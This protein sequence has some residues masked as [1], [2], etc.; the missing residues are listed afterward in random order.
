MVPWWTSECGE[1]IK[2]GNKAF[3]KLTN[4]SIYQ[5]LIEYKRRQAMVRKAV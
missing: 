1:A 2:L 4:N 3:K 5:K